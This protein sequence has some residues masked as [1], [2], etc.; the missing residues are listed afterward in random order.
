MQTC[1]I[2][3]NPTYIQL[4]KYLNKT[5]LKYWLIRQKS[6]STYLFMSEQI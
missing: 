2:L 5:S 1:V 4:I 6:D 3:S